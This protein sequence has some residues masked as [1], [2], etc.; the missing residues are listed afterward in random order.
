MAEMEEWSLDNF[1]AKGDKKKKEEEERSN[2]AASTEDAMG[3]AGG[4]S[5]AAGAVGSGVEGMGARLDE[6]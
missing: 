3:A 6:G 2:Q 4:S 5:R 1:F